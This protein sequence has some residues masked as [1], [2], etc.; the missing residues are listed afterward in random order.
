MATE[1]GPCFSQKK[2][3]GGMVRQQE[4]MSTETAVV[5]EKFRFHEEREYFVASRYG[6]REFG[7]RPGYVR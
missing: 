7:D 4:K 2:I 5:I 6:P 3:N 1:S